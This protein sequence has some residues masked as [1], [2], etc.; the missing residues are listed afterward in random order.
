MKTGRI[1]KYVVV[2][3]SMLVTG[4]VLLSA[5]TLGA[6]GKMSRQWVDKA[7]RRWS[8]QL[9]N[10][11][12]INYCVHNPYDTSFDSKRPII[13]MCNHASLYDIPLSFMAIP[14]SLRMLAKKELSHIPLMGG[15]MKAAG[16]PFVNRQNRR[17]A[18][19]DLENAKQLMESGV[20]IWI[21]PEGTRSRTGKMRPLK[22]GGF[23]MAIQSKALI[24]PL[25]IRGAYDILPPDSTGIHL[26]QTAH[27]HIGK[28]IDASRYTLA[29]KDILMRELESALRECAGQA[30]PQESNA[31]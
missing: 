7:S 26:N 8:K 14:G 6:V 25:G 28:P 29:E 12:K 9:L 13:V 15:G 24:V 16:F 23:I 3:R 2:A 30:L 1:Q 27:L 21:A 22:K 19:K 31:A 18:M 10:I 20:L 17:Q 5:M 11:A 4:W